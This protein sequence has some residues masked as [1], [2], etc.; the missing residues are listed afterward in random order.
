LNGKYLLLLAAVI[1]SMH[2]VPLD[3]AYAHKSEVVGDYKLEIGWD[4]EPPIIGM[5]NAITVMITHASDEEKASSEED[6]STH[7]GKSDHSGHEMSDSSHNKADHS[8]HIEGISGL[9]DILDVSITLNGKKTILDMV[10]DEHVTGL[11]HGKFTP[12]EAG[13]PTVSFFAEINGATIETTL[14]PEKVEGGALIR[15]ISSDGTINVDVIATVPTQDQSM[16]IG[17]DFTDSNG[18]AV[19]HVN[20]ALTAT[21]SETNILS[22][23]EAHAHHGTATHSTTA[24]KSGEPVDV[25]ITILGIGFPDKKS[26]WTGPKDDVI[27][28][29]VTPEFGPITMMVMGIALLSLVGIAGKTKLLSGI[30]TMF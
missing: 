7:D 23:P 16:L 12:Q 14:H 3:P 20:Y 27:P 11:Y 30:R 15:A 5:E 18:K 17:I 19:E 25:Q 1:A 9:A 21:Q 2:T 8:E 13:H 26:E 29:H 24:L 10:E 4:R 6:H 28:I 22:E